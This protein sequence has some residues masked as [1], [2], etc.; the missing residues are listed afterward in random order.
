MLLDIQ[1]R[2][3]RDTRETTRVTPT[4]RELPLLITPTRVNMVNSSSSSD[5]RS[6]AA[7]SERRGRLGLA[8]AKQETARR[9][10]ELAQANQQ[11]AEGELEEALA[12]SIAGSVGRIADLERSSGNSARGRPRSD[13]GAAAPPLQ[14]QLLRQGEHT[15]TRASS[16]S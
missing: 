8:R 10:V 2:A 3:R 4:L 15:P 9:Q 6:A 13:A 12:T 14:L 7:S 5:L 16:A 1:H 11:V